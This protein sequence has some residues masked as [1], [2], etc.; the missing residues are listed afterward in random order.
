MA[1]TANFHKRMTALRHKRILARAGKALIH[2]EGEI[3]ELIEANRVPTMIQH[4]ILK[5]SKKL[6]GNEREAFISAVNICS[7]TFSKYGYTNAGMKMTGKGIKRNRRHQREKEA[8]GKKGRYNGK[9]RKLWAASIKRMKE[10][11]S[12]QKKS[13]PKPVNM[14][15]RRAAR[16]ARK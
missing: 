11:R 8:S 12:Q 10:E 16:K 9:V 13:K 4:C 3:L 15:K 2:E 14:A 6:G 5:V 1:K 7:A